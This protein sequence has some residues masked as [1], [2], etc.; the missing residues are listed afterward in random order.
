MRKR[1]APLL[2]CL[3]ALGFFLN[4][5][6]ASYSAFHRVQKWNGG[7]SEKR[8][9]NSLVHFLMWLGPYELILLGDLLIFNTVE[10]WSGAP[11]F[12][13]GKES[14]ALQA[15]REGYAR[16][17][18]RGQVFELRAQNDRQLEIMIDQSLAATAEHREEGWILNDHRSGETLHFAATQ[19][20]VAAFRDRL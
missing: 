13:K 16:F 19:E 10:F 20:D 6:H 9:V 4:A 17:E 7:I 18:H 3:L 14:A 1:T 8:F 15:L 2:A 12:G 5:C 11:V